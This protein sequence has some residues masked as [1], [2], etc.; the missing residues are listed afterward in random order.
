MID[1][2]VL[3][4]FLTGLGIA[5]WAFAYYG[6]SRSPAKVIN[7]PA[8]LEEAKRSWAVV[9]AK[10]WAK[11]ERRNRRYIRRHGGRRLARAVRLSPTKHGLEVGQFYVTLNGLTVGMSGVYSPKPF[12]LYCRENV[13][14][15]EFADLREAFVAAERILGTPYDISKGLV[16]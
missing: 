7:E 3:R 13:N 16:K 9:Q 11:F 1:Q 8:E 14:P 6:I 10:R 2:A 15:R 5:G 12:Y 4:Q